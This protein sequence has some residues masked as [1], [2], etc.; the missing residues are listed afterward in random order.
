MV[1]PTVLFSGS[2][3]KLADPQDVA[4]LRPRI[5]NLEYSEEIPGWNHVDFLFGTDA[6]S[7]LYSRIL[8][9]L[10]QS[11]KVNNLVWNEFI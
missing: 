6:P 2:N 4:A 1:T 3:D 8:N 11:L 7:L 9:M 10:A 5:R